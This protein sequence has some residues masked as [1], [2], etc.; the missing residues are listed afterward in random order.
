MTTPARRWI[1]AAAAAAVLLAVFAAYLNPH[2]VFD[3]ANAVWAC[4]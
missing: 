1:A 4:F 2:F 3:V